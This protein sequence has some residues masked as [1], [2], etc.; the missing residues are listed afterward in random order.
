MIDF[1]PFQQVRVY[2]IARLSL[3]RVLAWIDGLYTHLV[4][5]SQYRL[6]FDFKLVVSIQDLANAP[7]AIKRM[8]C[9][10]LVNVRF[11]HQILF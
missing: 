2:Q 8:S 6:M 4:H 3:A 11:D 10:Y 7:I 1:K 5:M 9:I